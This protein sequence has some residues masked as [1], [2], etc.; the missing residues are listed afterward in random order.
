[1]ARIAIISL[2][3]FGGAHN[4]QTIAARRAAKAVVTIMSH[5][6]PE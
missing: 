6:G 3:I 1:M 5:D 4:R 2:A